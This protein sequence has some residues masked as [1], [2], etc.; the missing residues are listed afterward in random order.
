MP[1]TT[2]AL[3][4]VRQ[5]VRDDVTASLYGASIMPNG[6]LRVMADANAGLAHH[7][8]RF[9]EWLARQLMP[10]LAETEW[11]DRHGDI[12]LVNADGTVGRKMATYAAGQVELVADAGGIVLPAGTRLGSAR[13]QY[14]SAE[15]TVTAGGGAPVAMP[16]RALEPGIIGNLEPGDRLVLVSPPADVS[17]ETTVVRLGGGTETENDDDLRM[18][19]LQRIRQPPQGGAAHDYVRWALAVPGVTR[20]WCAPNEMG[21]GTV[22][23][24]VLM[25]VLRADDDGWPTAND[26]EAVT[27]YI[28]TVRPVAVKDFWV[29]APIKQLVDVHIGALVPDTIETRAA[30]EASLEKMFRDFAGPGQTIFAT[31]KA[32][33]VM[34]TAGVVSFDLLDWDDDVMPS[35]GHMG[36]L[37]DIVYSV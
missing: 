2:P 27:A 15:E 12:W 26:L 13:I 35:K 10:D 11:L 24:R 36:V 16:V 23:V 6:N 8:L 30:V 28:D 33:A 22:T 18:R 21:I 4:T 19:V 5:M 37:N 1:W 7:V 29:L 14:E 3:K 32:Q 25:D 31:W 20:A 17:A 34:N 9:I